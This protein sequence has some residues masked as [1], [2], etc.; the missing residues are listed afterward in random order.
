[1]SKCDGVNH[2]L[3]DLF[4]F[5]DAGGEIVVRWCGD[6]GAVAV[7]RDYDNRTHPGYY[8]PMKF[9]NMSY[10]NQERKP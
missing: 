5:H 6:C 2:R 7:D 10:P 8:V 4:D 9:P 1:M 3:L